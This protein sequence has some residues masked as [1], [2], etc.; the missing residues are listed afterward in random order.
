[1][2]PECALM[3]GI[4]YVS[5]VPLLIGPFLRTVWR[6]VVFTLIP[7]GDFDRERHQHD[8]EKVT[9]ALVG[10]VERPLYLLSISAGAHG[11]V[12]L[13]LAIKMAG[14]WV[15]WS[16]GLGGTHDQRARIPGR[17]VFGVSLAGS[18]LSVGFAVAAHIGVLQL[19][20]GEFFDGVLAGGFPVLYILM[21]WGYFG[22]CL[23]CK[24]KKQK[25]Q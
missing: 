16:H 25:S 21:V 9:P 11:L 10:L 5:F 1:M 14:G 3:V 22:L 12:G 19:Q 8:Y 24:K 18:G 13:W 7:P 2:A 4:V 20:S 6:L 17:S 15:R 23:W